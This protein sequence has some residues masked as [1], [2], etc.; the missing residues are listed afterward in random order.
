MWT[1][2]GL[3]KAGRFTGRLAY[4]AFHYLC[5]SPMTSAASMSTFSDFRTRTNHK[6]EVA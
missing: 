6:A 4:N 1:R 3:S 2:T 5:T